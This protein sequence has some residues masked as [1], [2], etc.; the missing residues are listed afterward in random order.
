[1]ERISGCLLRWK[2]LVACLFFDESQQ[3]TCPHS[4]HRRRC[5]HVSPSLMHS[6]QTSVSVDLNLICLMWLQLWAMGFSFKPVS[7]CRTGGRFLGSLKR[8]AV[9]LCYRS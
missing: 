1:M 5:T 4:K 2:C 6:S 8:G 7:S 3:P 9:P